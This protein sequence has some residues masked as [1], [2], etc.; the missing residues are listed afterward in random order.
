M[1]AW[2]MIGGKTLPDRMNSQPQS[3]DGAITA[4]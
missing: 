2:E 1:I 3:S 4:S